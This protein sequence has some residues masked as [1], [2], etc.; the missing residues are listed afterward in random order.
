MKLPLQ[1][2][3]RDSL[4]VCATLGLWF[5][6]RQLDGLSTPLA[7]SVA[8]AA[9][10]MTAVSGYLAHEWGHLCGALLRG[11]VV[12]LPKGITAV[13]LFKFN[14]EQNSREQ[15]LWMSMGGFVSSALI[16]ALLLAL[17][18]FDRL[19]DQVA[20]GLTLAGVIATLVLEVPP[21][22]RVYRGAALPRG[23]AYSGS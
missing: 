7:V 9:G 20:L 13:F 10:V 12:E 18:S 8:I 2:L 23:A 21:A 17:L 11:S 4:L 16:V 14:S 1:L 5:W 3:A 19:A 6:S 15:F 22:V